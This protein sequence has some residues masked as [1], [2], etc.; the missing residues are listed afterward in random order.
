[1]W[2]SLAYNNW[3]YWQLYHKI[4]VDYNSRL[5]FINK[6]IVDFD[7]KVDLYSDLK[8]LWS[9]DATEYKYSRYKPP[10]RVIGGD[11]TISGQFAGDIYFMQGNWRVVYDPTKT[12]VSGVLF[13]DDY[14][15]PWL[16]SKDLSPIYP[17]QVA[18]LVTAVAPSLEGLNIPTAN[19]NAKAIWDYALSDILNDDTVGAHVK[20]KLLSVSKYLGLK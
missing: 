12:K 15:T 11:S 7:I 10:V 4:T 17:A 9:L 19:E 16:Y 6:D 20:N 13:S 1:M 5:I 18:S 2:T 8:E 14:D 3:D